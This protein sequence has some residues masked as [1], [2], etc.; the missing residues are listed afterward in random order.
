VSGENQSLLRG[1]IRRQLASSGHSVRQEAVE[2]L[3][4]DVDCQPGEANVEV[5]ALHEVD[6]ANGVRLHWRITAD[7]AAARGAAGGRSKRDDRPEEPSRVRH[8]AAA[9]WP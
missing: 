1:S 2:V 4:D 3:V 7:P 9:S 5:I 6:C 8:A